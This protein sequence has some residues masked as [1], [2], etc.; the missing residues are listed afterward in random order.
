MSDEEEKLTDIEL[1]IDEDGK[2][3]FQG[4]LLHDGQQIELFSTGEIYKNEQTE[5]SGVYGDLIL[6]DMADC[7]DIHFVQ[8]RLDKVNKLHPM[9]SITLQAVDTKELMYF[10]REISEETF[11]VL[12]NNSVNSLHGEELEDKIVDLYSINHNIIDRKENRARR[13]VNS[14]IHSLDDTQSHATSYA[15]W[16][17]FIKVLETHSKVKLSDFSDMVDVSFFKGNGWSFEDSTSNLLYSV[18]AYSL[19]NGLGEYLA[20]ITL[21]DI[22]AQGHA[23]TE[24]DLVEL[25]MQ[26]EYSN[27][28]LVS[29]SEITDEVSVIYVQKGVELQDFIIA[30]NGLTN[31]A[32]FVRR[33]VDVYSSSSGSLVRATIALSP[34]AYQILTVFDNLQPYEDVMAGTIMEFESTYERQLQKYSG[35]II[36]GLAAST[37]N[38][39]MRNVGHRIVLEGILRCKINLGTQWIFGYDYNAITDI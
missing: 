15:G 7:D 32:V 1:S 36:T 31:E 18:A 6:G 3:V 11:D 12:Y 38:Q 26:A 2:L 27:G 14:D 20:Q 29:Y 19:R 16:D 24:P 33:V 5:N 4:E 17:Q 21:T 22:I 39:K 25:R 28:I 13:S 8:L 37:G 35:K 10:S 34:R 23:G 30:M 9:L